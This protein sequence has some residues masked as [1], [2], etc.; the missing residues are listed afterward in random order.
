M[1]KWVE[2]VEMEP[3]D[4]DGSLWSVSFE[5]PLNMADTSMM[6]IMHYKYEIQTLEG[7]RIPEGQYERS[8]TRM[9]KSFFHT[10]RPNFTHLRFRGI[11]HQPNATAIE[12]FVIERLT[13]VR[14]GDFTPRKFLESYGELM[15]C[16]PSGQRVLIENL[17]NDYLNTSEVCIII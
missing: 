7:E 2:P 15:D 11:Q 5:T 16:I 17:F 10:F 8:E 13:R 9:R 12:K 6:G 3:S 1:G 14:R 4:L